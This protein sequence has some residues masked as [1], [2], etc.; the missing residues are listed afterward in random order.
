MDFEPPDFEA[1]Y[2]RHL[3]RVTEW[4]KSTSNPLLVMDIT[5]GEGWEKLCNFLHP[6]KPRVPFPHEN[7]SQVKASSLGQ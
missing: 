3:D 1:A 5:A 4:F 6:P 2:N 7:R